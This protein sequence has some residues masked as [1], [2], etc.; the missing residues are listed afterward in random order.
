MYTLIAVKFNT[1]LGAYFCVKVSVGSR[2]KTSEH[3]SKQMS[4]QSLFIG[5]DDGKEVKRQQDRQDGLT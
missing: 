1:M 2:K 3:L 4:L 5:V